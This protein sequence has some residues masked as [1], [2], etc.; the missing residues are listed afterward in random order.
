MESWSVAYFQHRLSIVGRAYYSGILASF[1]AVLS[2]RHCNKRL[3]II[4]TLVEKNIIF[5]ACTPC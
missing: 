1:C 4:L 3:V 2:K 5:N